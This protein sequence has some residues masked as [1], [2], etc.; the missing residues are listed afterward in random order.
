MTP[1]LRTTSDS[2]NAEIRIVRFRWKR[3]NPCHEPSVCVSPGAAG[4]LGHVD[5]SCANERDGQKKHADESVE[6]GRE[7]VAAYVG[8]VHYAEG[9]HAAAQGA[10]AHHEKTP[11]T[12]EHARHKHNQ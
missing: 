2:V 12:A 3:P 6:A 7:F 11:P 1:I 8:Y 5:A 4:V 10:G 9:L